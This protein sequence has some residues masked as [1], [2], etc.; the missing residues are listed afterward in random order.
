MET[1]HNEQIMEIVKG[2]FGTCINGY[3]EYR[4]EGMTIECREWRGHLDNEKVIER[5]RGLGIMN[6]E[7][8]SWAEEW[9]I[10]T[11]NGEAGR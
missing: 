9:S 5:M 8:R 3:F 7:L 10:E 6:R 1:W 4:V 11:D 2:E